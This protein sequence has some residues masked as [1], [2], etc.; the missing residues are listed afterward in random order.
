MYYMA[1]G[2]REML[3]EGSTLS[4]V[5]ATRQGAVKL[6]SVGLVP[7]PGRHDLIEV[8]GAAETLAEV[9]RR[10]GVKIRTL[11]STEARASLRRRAVRPSACG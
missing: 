4:D 6:E 7:F 3:E 5:L 9:R 8:D 10:F 2:M 1:A 11:L